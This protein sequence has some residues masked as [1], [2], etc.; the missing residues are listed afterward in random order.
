MRTYLTEGGHCGRFN[1]R[2]R[3]AGLRCLSAFPGRVRV[4]GSGAAKV[5]QLG[6]GEET[7]EGQVSADEC[8]GAC[9][10]ELGGCG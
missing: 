10:G 6:E 4:V 5:G 3:G 7:K 2:P 8:E 9:V 1:V